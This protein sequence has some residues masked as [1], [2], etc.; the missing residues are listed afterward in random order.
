MTP[1]VAAFIAVPNWIVIGNVTSAQH[2][3]F[4]IEFALKFIIEHGQTPKNASNVC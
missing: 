1:A 3:T 2:N 4:R